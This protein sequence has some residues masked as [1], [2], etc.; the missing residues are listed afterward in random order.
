VGWATVSTADS[1]IG[2]AFVATVAATGCAA[3]VSTASGGTTVIGRS[4]G[5]VGGRSLG[6]VGRSLGAVGR[7]SIRGLVSLVAEGT[8]REVLGA[9]A[10][11]STVALRLGTIATVGFLLT[12]STIGFG[13]GGRSGRSIRS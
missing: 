3:L 5:A 7:R 8:V 12:V 10:V 2:F 6:T 1:T 11:L 4:L 9:I 13:G